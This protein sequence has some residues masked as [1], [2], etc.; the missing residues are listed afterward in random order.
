MN[1]IDINLI[2]KIR[3][4]T[5]ASLLDCK[6]ILILTNGNIKKAIIEMRKLGILKILKKKKKN[7]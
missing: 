7:Y 1:K 3:N 6:N 5:G 2:K 4:I